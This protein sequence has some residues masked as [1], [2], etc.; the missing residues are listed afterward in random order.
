LREI[1]DRELSQTSDLFQG[2]QRQVALA[3]FH[4]A[5]VRAVHADEICKDRLA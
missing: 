5:Q 4:S 1:Y 3:T 2:E